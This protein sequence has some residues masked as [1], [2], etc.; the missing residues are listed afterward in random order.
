MGRW[1][2]RLGVALLLVVATPAA[3]RAQ[4]VA[5]EPPRTGGLLDELT[6][7]R[8]PTPFSV[9][10]LT[11]PDFDL[12][13]SWT[14]GLAIPRRGGAATAPVGLARLAAEGHVLARRRLYVGVALPLA[15]G[16]DLTREGAATPPLFGNVEAHV[17]V[18]LPMPSWL[19]VGAHLGVVA[20]TARFDRNG[21]AQQAALAAASL[22]PTDA[23]HFLPGRAALRPALD[24][25]ILRGRFVGHL[26]QGLDVLVDA[27]GVTPVTTAGR[28]LGH[29]GWLVTPELEISLE[30]TQLYVVSA[31]TPATV[32]APFGAPVDP[33]LTDRR[34]N[35]TTF[36]LGARLSSK[37]VDLGAA[38]LT[39]LIDPLS[40]GLDRVVGLRLSVVPHIR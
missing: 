6:A 26:R 37:D 9:P 14:P 21:P 13:A 25:R 29:A 27:A 3:A 38:L 11:H 33:Q 10:E 4:G 2:R 36:A 31:R 12:S 22:E 20:P 8:L 17:R 23:A 5:A 18:V 39:D 15:L 28:L 19:A 1:L 34:R 16:R 7:P 30:A 40:I 32:S 24:F 35:A